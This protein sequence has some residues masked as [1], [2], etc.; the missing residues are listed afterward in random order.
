MKKIIKKVEKKFISFL[1]HVNVKI[2]SKYLFLRTQRKF[3]NLKSPKTFNEK[4]MYIKLKYYLNDPIIWKCVD[5]YEVRQFLISKGINVNNLP[6]LID[7][8]Q[9]AEDIDF[10]TLPNK[11]ALKCS[12]GCGFNIIC[13]DKSKIEE[14]DAKDKLN[15]WLNTKFGYETAETQYLHQKPVIICEKYIDSNVGFPFDYKIYCFNGIAKCCLVCSN[16]E[17]ELQL[18][19]FD[20]NWNELYFGKEHLRNKELIKKPKNFDQMIE[21]AEKCSKDFPFVRVDFYEYNDIP[22]IGELT[23]TPA[24]CIANYYTDYGQEILASYFDFDI[25]DINDKKRKR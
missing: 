3:L 19:F 22:I 1:S 17:K 23:F 7:L 10:S 21:M 25:L 18:N 8:Y 12:H 2:A 16:R 13:S 6:T 24:A 11:F 5:K 14:K 20:L 9:N 4:L 15:K